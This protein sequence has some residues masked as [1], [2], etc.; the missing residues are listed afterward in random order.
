MLSF[1]FW[2]FT[3]HS[4]LGIKVCSHK[5]HSCVCVYLVSRKWIIFLLKIRFP[6]VSLFA[7]ITLFVH[8]RDDG[9]GN[10]NAVLVL[11]SAQL[12]HPL[13]G[14]VQCQAVSWRQRRWAVR[15]ALGLGQAWLW[16]PAQPPK[17]LTLIS[18]MASSITL[19]SQG[20]WRIICG[21]AFDIVS[22]T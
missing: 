9:V 11:G 17:F 6:W 21:K 18:S 1:H 7:T 10:D 22:R 14:L 4:Y 8:F 13:A 16:V 19:M 20:C 5:N 15:R 3:S 2:D 12:N